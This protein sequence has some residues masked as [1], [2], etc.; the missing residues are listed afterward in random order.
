MII[1]R[2]CT[3]VFSIVYLRRLCSVLV[4]MLASSECVYSTLAGKVYINVKN[5]LHSVPQRVCVI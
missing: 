4:W 2:T 1:P 3:C 5:N